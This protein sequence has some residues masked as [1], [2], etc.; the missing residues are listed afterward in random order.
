MELA[1]IKDSQWNA[2]RKIYTEAFPK[3]EQ[4]SFTSLKSSVKKGKTE[5]L[6]A[7]ENDTLLGCPA[8]RSI[9]RIS[10]IPAPLPY[11][12]LKQQLLRRDLSRCISPTNLYL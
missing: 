3:K 9:H 2:V 5:L 11:I 7:S 6:T 12:V 8:R 1:K 10:F 4:K